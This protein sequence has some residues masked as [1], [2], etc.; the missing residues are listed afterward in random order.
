MG[1]AHSRRKGATYEREVAQQ[2]TAAFG[3]PVARMLGQARDGGHDLEVGPYVIE[4]KRRKTL[5]TIA[6]WMR[7]CL[8][9]MTTHQDLEK[10]VPV[11]IARE[12]AGESLV[13]MRLEDWLRLAP[14]SPEA[15]DA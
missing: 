3:V 6:A 7:Q 11:I 10:T 15:T 5:P 1:G 13:I 12:D 14:V 9:A 2:L 8:L 4:C